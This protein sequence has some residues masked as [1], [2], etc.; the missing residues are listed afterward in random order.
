M[1][2]HKREPDIYLGFSRALPLQCVL[3]GNE[4]TAGSHLGVL[5]L[6]R[7]LEDRNALHLLKEPPLPRSLHPLV[8]LLIIR[9]PK[10]KTIISN[11]LLKNLIMTEMPSTF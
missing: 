7:L 5:K 9:P 11:N 8:L 3:K 6:G 4:E 1:G 10:K 2:K